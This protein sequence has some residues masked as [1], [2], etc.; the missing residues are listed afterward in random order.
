MKIF[1]S[2]P[3][4]NLDP[5][6]NTRNAILAAE[7]VIERGH[8]PFIPHLNHLWH[9]I[10]PHEPDFWYDYDLQWLPICDVILRLPG[11]SEGADREVRWAERL[12]IRVIY[13]I[14]EL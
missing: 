13:D 7:K 8:I 3:Y 2:G 5:C 4:T 10:S 9:L 1:I 14:D 6:I 12:H 11:E